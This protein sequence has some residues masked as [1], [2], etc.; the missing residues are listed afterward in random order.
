MKCLLSVWTLCIAEAATMAV[1][2]YQGEKSWVPILGLSILLL[3]VG[4]FVIFKR[5]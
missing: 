5:K 2:M 1:A 3:V 4:F